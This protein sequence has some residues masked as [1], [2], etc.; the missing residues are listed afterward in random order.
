MYVLLYTRIITYMYKIIH[1]CI[2]YYLVINM[3][4]YIHVL[5]GCNEGLVP[6][7]SPLCFNWTTSLRSNSSSGKKIIFL[8]TL[9]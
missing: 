8:N 1:V 4:Y 2:M 9:A 7:I 5:F 3:H 6:E